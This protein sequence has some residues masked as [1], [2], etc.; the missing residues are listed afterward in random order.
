MTSPEW[1]ALDLKGNWKVIIS[2][3]HHLSR[4]EN[5]A[6]QLQIPAREMAMFKE[7]FKLN[8]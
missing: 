4:W 6:I 8:L 7:R 2:I 1:V 3:C 5:L